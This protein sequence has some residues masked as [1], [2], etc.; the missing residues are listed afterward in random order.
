MR[1]LTFVALTFSALLAACAS[2]ISN[3]VM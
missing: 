3:L 2:E 1:I